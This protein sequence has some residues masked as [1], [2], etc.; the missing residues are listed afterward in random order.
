MSNAVQDV[1]RPDNATVGKAAE[2]LN[3]S[4]RT[5]WRLINDGDLPSVRF[6][7]AVRVR[8]VDLEQFART[9]TSAE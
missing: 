1:V 6:G 9:G 5:V 3:L 4:E 2:F 7:R 8:W